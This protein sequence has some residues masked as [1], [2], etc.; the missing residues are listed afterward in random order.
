MNLNAP[1]K[2]EW[3]RVGSETQARIPDLSSTLIL[4]CPGLITHLWDGKKSLKFS[5][6]IA[7]LE[8]SPTEE[9]VLL[10]IA[11]T[12]QMLSDL[13]NFQFHFV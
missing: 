12:S 8:I 9:S 3:M 5:P 2:R 11:I 7:I 10:D 4:D 13:T 1:V 6:C